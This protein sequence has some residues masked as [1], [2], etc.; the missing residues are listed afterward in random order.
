MKKIIE[1]LKERKIWRTL[2][3]YP[4]V[5]FVLLQAVEFFINNYDLD[6]RYLSATFIACVAF[7]PVALIWNWYH[8]ETGHQDFRKA[9]IGAYGLF[10]MV[11]IS[12]VAWFWLTTERAASPMASTAEPVRSIAVM[13]FLNPGEDAG[14]QYLC[15]GIAESLINWL[16][17]QDAVKVSSKS[18]SFRLREDA[19]DAMEIGE[20]LGVDSVL[21][22]KLERVGEQIVISASL[23]DARDG[24]QIWGERL[25]RPDSELLYLERNIVDAI[26]AGLKINVTDSGSKL[27]ASGGTDNPE[28]YEKYLRGHFLIQATEAGSIDEGLEELRAAIRLDPGFGLP[29]AD[30]ADALIQKIYYAIERSPELVGEARTAALSAVALAPDS[31]EAHT[32]LAGVYAYFDFDWAAAEQAFEKAIALNPNS[33]VPYHRYSDFLWLTLRTTRALE[34]AYK[35]VEQDPIDSSSLHAVGLSYLIAGNYDESSRAFG[36]WN[37]FHPQSRWSY[38][39]YAVALSLNGQCD[40][41]MERLATVRQMTNDEASMLRESWMALSY[42][43]CNEQALFAR[44]AERIEADLAEDG[45]G[46]PAALIWLR[47]MQGDIESSVAIVQR[48]IESRSDLAPFVQLFGIEVWGSEGFGELG[49][50]ARYIEMVEALNFPAVEN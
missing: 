43:I 39:K 14:V 5:S 50:D 13:P 30:I 37:R 1:E 19:D 9:E 18:A 3:A 36:E 17:A 2:I 44:S 42:H 48:A 10:T 49:R 33:P 31:A 28:A 26:T 46:D 12:L 8:G 35:A 6:A 32:A 40:I 29:Y 22:G 16:A 4:G 38:V 15:D 25:M 23:V 34:M 45:V 24:S 11:A 7:L 20:R 41:S 27:A 47:L 21:Q